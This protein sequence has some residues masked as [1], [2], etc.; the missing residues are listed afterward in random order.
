[1]QSLK[2]IV[3][4]FLTATAL[5]LLGLMAA[6]PISHADAN[7]AP[8]PSFSPTADRCVPFDPCP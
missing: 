3:S 6:S 8:E 1:M 2:L 4:A 5:F 7:R